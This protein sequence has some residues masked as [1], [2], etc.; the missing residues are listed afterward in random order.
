MEEW[1]L[2][3][4]CSIASV[5]PVYCVVSKSKL[6]VGG[7]WDL[8]LHY[9]LPSSYSSTSRDGIVCRNLQAAYP[10]LPGPLEVS[11]LYLPPCL[12]L[13]LQI[14]FY[15]W[16][17]SCSC[18]FRHPDSFSELPIRVVWKSSRM[19]INCRLPQPGVFPLSLTF[20]FCACPLPTFCL[21]W[22]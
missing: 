12:I 14:M 1:K 9:P 11:S 8:D 3:W 19:A 7:L 6:L 17:L 18:P 5:P 21:I 22:T 2:I 13:S 4:E 15:L 16:N 10:P 20:F